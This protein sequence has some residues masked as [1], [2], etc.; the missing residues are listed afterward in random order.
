MIFCSN[1]S[2]IESD[3]FSRKQYVSSPLGLPK[4]WCKR[5]RIF[6]ETFLCFHFSWM[7]L[8]LR[9]NEMNFPNAKFASWKQLML[10]VF[11]QHFLL[12]GRNFFATTMFLK[13]SLALHLCIVVV[14]S[15]C[16]ERMRDLCILHDS[17]FA[18]AFNA[19][20]TRKIY[21]SMMYCL[22]LLKMFVEERCNSEWTNWTNV[23]PIRS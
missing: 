15:T 21:K 8:R 13:V 9:I 12:P 4:G 14:F 23:S 5:G 17:S 6:L 11:E 7:F 22:I 2:Q 10:L 19:W 3:I 1:S 20:S 18:L 16:S